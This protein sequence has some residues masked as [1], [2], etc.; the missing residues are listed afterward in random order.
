MKT[1]EPNQQLKIS[2]KNPEM[3]ISAQKYIDELLD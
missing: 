2:G 1:A 3:A